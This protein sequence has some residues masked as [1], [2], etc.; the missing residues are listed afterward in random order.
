M[1]IENLFHI[2]LFIILLLSACGND[3]SADRSKTEAFLQL[4]ADSTGVELHHLDVEAIEYLKSDS[5]GEKEWQSFFSV[6]PDSKDPELRGLQV[7]LSGN[8]TIRDSIIFFTPAEKFK[9]DS[10]YFARFYRH[11][12]LSSSS[13]II[14]GRKIF[15]QSKPIELVFKP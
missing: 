14:E 3:Q 12:L 1:K 2:I 8:Y 6:Y 15:G 4:S 7:P 13:E 10:V 11:A 9:K 5:I